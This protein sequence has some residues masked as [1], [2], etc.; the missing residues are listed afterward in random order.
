MNEGELLEMANTLKTK[1]EDL[2]NKE[3]LLEI[4][5]LEFTKS[6]CGIYGL[7]RLLDNMIDDRIDIVDLLINELRSDISNLLFRQIDIN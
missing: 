6:L 4:Q 7:I 5:M 2:E 3:K 1:F